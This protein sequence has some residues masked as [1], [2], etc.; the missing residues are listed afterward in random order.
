[1]TR[2][3]RLPT[4][5]AEERLVTKKRRLATRAIAI[6][7]HGRSIF[8]RER[9]ANIIYP[10]GEADRRELK[11]KTQTDALTG[12]AN[13]DAL[14][15]ALPSAEQDVDVAI[16]F[17]DANNFG[18]I[19]KN[20][21]DSEGDVAIKLIAQHL[22]KITEEII[23]SQERV[24]RKG[25]DEFVILAPKD[26]AQE[27]RD[28]IISSYGSEQPKP[29]GVVETD[30]GV[31]GYISYGDIIVSLSVGIGN[32]KDEADQDARELKKEIQNL[33]LQNF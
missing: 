8:S 31:I 17:I 4:L 18:L 11:R 12:L 23:G 33:K 32:T 24:F 21:S 5:K 22:A 10:Q 1:M 30:R 15:S 13:F 14:A 20:I 27:L 29:I 2:K 28:A 3:E 6:A 25:G 26:R 9:F 19:N 7:S 16:L